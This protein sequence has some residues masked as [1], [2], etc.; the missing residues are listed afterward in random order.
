MANMYGTSSSAT[1]AA[2]RLCVLAPKRGCSFTFHASRRCTSQ[3]CWCPAILAQ[4]CVGE[5]YE[6]F[7]CMKLASAA[8]L[9]KQNRSMLRVHAY[10]LPELFRRLALNNVHMSKR[11]KDP[12]STSSEPA[13]KRQKIFTNAAGPSG[14][15]QVQE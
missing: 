4:G 10:R 8:R 12:A 9:S 6:G 3:T 5:T 13:A 7:A 1:S 2:L 15:V 11:S 14:E